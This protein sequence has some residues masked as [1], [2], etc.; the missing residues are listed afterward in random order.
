MDAIAAAAR[1]RPATSPPP[2]NAANSV[3]PTSRTVC[4]VSGSSRRLGTAEAST[5][6]CSSPRRA[7]S[8]SASS[9]TPADASPA[10]DVTTSTRSTPG[11]PPGPIA[12]SMTVIAL[13]RRYPVQ[14]APAPQLV[15]FHHLAPICPAEVGQ[16]KGAGKNRAMNTAS[17]ST[18]LNTPLRRAPGTDR[19]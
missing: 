6:C 12:T 10:G 5:A 4:S 19:C 8:A 14:P 11:A 15:I 1:Y 2:S 17:V 7:S 3:S 13:A 9:S 16:V 18:L